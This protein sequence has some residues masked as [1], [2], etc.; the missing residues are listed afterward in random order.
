MSKFKF[1]MQL[2][3]YND[4]IART[5]V[6][7]PEE[8]SKEILQDIPKAS[9]M[10][11]LMRKLPNMA[12]GVAKLPVLSTLPNAYFVN[13]TDTGHKQT[14]KQAWENVSITAEEIAC[15]VP[16]PEA[17]LD[18]ADYDI[19]GEVKP[20][21]VEAF[22]ALF[23]AAVMFGTNKPASWPN[24]IVT[25]AI[26][27]GHTVTIGTGDDI[28]DDIGGDGGVMSLIE[29]DGFSVN[30][31]AAAS[32]VKAK[33]RGLRA[34]TGELI[35]QPSLQAGTPSTLYGSPIVYDENG[36]WNDAVALMVAGDFR[37]ALYAIRQDMTYKI[38]D[39]A[40]ITDADGV[41]QYN[42]AQQDMVALRC[43][44][45]LGWV[46]PNPVTRK[47]TNKATRCAFGVL[48]P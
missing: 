12:R 17:V 42:L 16:I 19:W 5:D 8:V 45:R 29:A 31:F 9:L 7:I 14:T 27:A 2:F 6:N 38:L 36:A 43:V 1:D 3:A 4:K 39:Q 20:R 32:T 35:F 13:P 44:M 15:I 34:S 28:A 47:N 30:G 40:V 23:D 46:L 37:Q 41:I 21:I 10:M 33:L 26:A 48:A 25:Q 18:D 22:G 11:Q 24:G